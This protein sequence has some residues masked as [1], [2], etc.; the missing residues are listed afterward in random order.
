MKALLARIFPSAKHAITALITVILVVGEWRFGI[1]GGYPKLVVTLGSCVLLEAALSLFLL[2][3][4]PSL[5]SAYIT[6]V[7]LTILLRP[8]GGLYWPFVAGAILSIGSKY[9]LRYR[10]RHLWNPSNLG[11]AVL[12]L[13]APN[14]LAILSHEFGNDVLGNAV[15]WTLGLLI[16]SRAKVLHITV[17]YAASFALLALARAAILPNTTAMAELAPLTGPMYQLMAF[18]MLTDPRTTVGTLR[19]RVLVVGIIAVLEALLR[20]GNDLDVP[21]AALFAPAPPILA[22][23]IVGPIAL[24]IDLRRRAESPAQPAPSPVAPDAALAPPPASR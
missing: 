9:V 23:A 5:Q 20:I 1:V 19:G 18:F 22:L 15:I 12:V 2:G 24:A 7:S 14:Q 13:L 11:I 3:R 8:A 10:G 21:F 17:T 6:G 4:W 16:A